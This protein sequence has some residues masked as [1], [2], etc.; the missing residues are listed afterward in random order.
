MGD[1]RYARCLQGGGVYVE[2]GTVAI[3]SST[4]SG[5]TAT[6]VK[7]FLSHRPWIALLL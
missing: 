7:A 6:Y 4:I 1:S 5:N 3:S 2:R